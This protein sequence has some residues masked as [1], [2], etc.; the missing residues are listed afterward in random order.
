MYVGPQYGACFV[1]TRLVPK[2]PDTFIRFFENLYKPRPILTK[3]GHFLFST[4]YFERNSAQNHRDTGR[5]GRA[6]KK[7]F[8]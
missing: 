1:S 7:V 6:G 2:I 3:R 8:P 4:S 5:R